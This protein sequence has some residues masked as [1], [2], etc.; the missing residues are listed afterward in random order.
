VSVTTGN[1]ADADP[2]YGY[3]GLTLNYG[4]G[5]PNMAS[6]PTSISKNVLL[7]ASLATVDTTVTITNSGTMAGTPSLSNSGSATHTA[8]SPSG[9]I[10]SGGG[11]ATTVV[12]I[13]STGTY[14]TVTGSVL[15]TTTGDTSSG[16]DTTSI[17]VNV[18]NA[19]AHAGGG[20][21][22][23]NRLTAVVAAGAYPQLASKVTAGSDLTTSDAIILA[24]TAGTARPDVGMNW[25]TRTAIEATQAHNQLGMPA[26]ATGLLSDVVNVDGT[27]G[28]TYVLQ[29]TYDPGKIFFNDPQPSDPEQVLINHQRLFLAWLDGSTWKNAVEGI[30]A[31]SAQSV[32]F[33]GTWDQFMTG[34]GSDHTLA[35]LLGSW[36]VDK[37]SDTVWAVVN[38]NSQY[39]V[40]PEPGTVA[41]LALLALSLPR[42]G[43]VVALLRRRR[44]A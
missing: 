9:A 1:V 18:G 43:S 37:G 21:L 38:H 11:T 16:N 13:A 6:S 22:A 36:G 41:L 29:M 33:E 20:F 17:T 39:A 15:A 8:L 4:A 31:G 27:G 19:T 34:P 42:R 7:N 2:F 40:M 24:G 23:G 25:R 14:G 3:V 35:E 30:T 28:D 26:W 12:S 32:N 10:A 44:R 5:A